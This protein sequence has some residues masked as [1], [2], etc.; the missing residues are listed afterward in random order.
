MG[1]TTDLGGHLLRADDALVRLRRLW[2]SPHGRLLDDAGR[3]IE[4]SSVLVVEAC[5]RAAA[6]GD[7]PSVGDIARFTGVEHSTASRLVERAAR[8]RLV[9][10]VRSDRDGRRTAVRLTA[11]GRA[12]R[13]RAMSFRLAWL[14]RLLDGW[15]DDDV[16]ALS[17]LLG[18]FA[19]AAATAGPPGPLPSGGNPAG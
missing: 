3:Q 9:E 17:G 19:D 8:A 13:E 12:V 18:R 16:V 1:G 10:R 4:M 6:H 15:S 11:E 14:R 2:S 5:A 7:E